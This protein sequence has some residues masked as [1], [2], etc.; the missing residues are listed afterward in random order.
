MRWILLVGLLA[1]AFFV[2]GGAKELSLPEGASAVGLAWSPDGTGVVVPYL[3]GRE[4]LVECFMM[5]GG[6]SRWHTEGLG[7]SLHPF[8]PV[9]SPVEEALAV[10]GLNAVW[11]LSSADGT[12]LQ[13]IEFEERFH[14][15]AIAFCLDGSLAVVVEEVR[16]FP[17][18]L[19]LELWNRTGNLQD[20]RLLGKRHTPA[21]QAKAAFS[22]DGRWLA[23]AAGSETEPDGEDWG[24]YLLDLESGSCQSWDLRELLPGLP[25][26]EQGVAIAGLAVRPD[27]EEIAVGLHSVAPGN[28]LVLR[29]DAKGRLLGTYFTS[30]SRSCMARYMAYSPDCGL[31][32][33]SVYSP[34]HI[35]SAAL[36]ILNLYG[37]ESRLI[38]LCRADLPRDCPYLYVL[39]VFSP[40]GQALATLERDRV[41]FW[42]LCPGALKLPA[43]DWSFSFSSGGAYIPTGRGEWSVRLDAEGRLDIAHLM[44]ETIQPYGPFQLSTQE[45]MEL[46]TLIQEAEI[47]KKQSSTRPGIP[48]EARQLFVLEGPTCRFRVELWQGEAREDEDLMVLIEKLAALIEHYTGEEPI[49]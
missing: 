45:A 5:P 15:L 42:E 18:S 38:T 11:L 33:F 41:R 19:Y 47:P 49:L 16:G 40:D 26:E 22:A 28:P 35:K 10:R 37:D 32:A 13:T 31:L 27:G 21:R 44:G 1:S 20:R 34:I 36:A 7:F 17:G 6:K 46:W 3:M 4:G 23:F 39:P 48:D 24:L 29:L 2:S 9:F 30:E 25:W 12:I 43:S 8:S 14:P